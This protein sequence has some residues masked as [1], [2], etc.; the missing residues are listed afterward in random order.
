MGDHE[1]ASRFAAAHGIVAAAATTALRLFGE[2][3]SLTIELK[4]R[5]DW[6]SEADR[7]VEREIRV[8]L[9]AAFP[10]DGI[11]G[12]EHA[13]TTGTSGY[14]WVIDPIDGTSLFVAG[15]PGWCVVLA[16]VHRGET[17][18]AAI[19]DPIARETFLARRGHG[20]TFNGQAMRVSPATGLDQG[21]VSVGH[22]A[23]VPTAPTLAVL[24]A[25][26]AA[27]S[28][29]QRTGSGALCLCMV[30][31]GRLIG[32]IESHMNAWD[33]IAGMLLIEEAGGRVERF[34]MADMLE[35]GGRVIAAGPGVYDALLAV[36]DR[37][38]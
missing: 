12:E 26:L 34:D 37:T 29:Y 16:C 4:G 19:I 24:D 8:A 11:I 27:G 30:S 18:L 15:S 22:S 6:V 2:L 33:C 32:Y 35:S 23:R 31:A 38:L 7:G 9:G 17:V 25:L 21:S 1:L 14:T 36:A 5:Q 3:D 28:L 20:A 13:N 10:D